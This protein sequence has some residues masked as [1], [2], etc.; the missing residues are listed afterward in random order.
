MTDAMLEDVSRIEH[1]TALKLGGSRSVTDAGVRHLSRLP[2]LRYL[3]LS[4]TS[5]T[6][7]GLE[8]L[9]ALPE[10]ETVSL[11]WTKVTDAGVAHLSGCERLSNVNLQGTSSGDG[12]LR[13]L[14]GKAHLCQLRTGNAVTDAGLALLHEM[15]IFKSWHGGEPK[16]GL[17]SYDAGPNY[18]LL[19]GPIHG[20]RHDAARRPL[21]PLRLEPGRFRARH[22]RGG[23][24]AVG[25][26]AKPWLARLRCDRR[27]HA[28]HRSHAPAPLPWLPGHR[29]G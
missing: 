16:M 12:A 27:C 24:G 5:I 21:R 2:R 1:I 3:D 17:L 7:H 25:R 19:R 4:G 22:H 23:A 20:S 14:A 6:D 8:V 10:L 28:V 11:A 18:L 9:R 15:P 26:V 29:R 13:A